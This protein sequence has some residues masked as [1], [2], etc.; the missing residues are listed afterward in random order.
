MLPH[1]VSRYNLSWKGYSSQLGDQHLQPLRYETG[2]RR[3]CV[4]VETRSA[5]ARSGRDRNILRNSAP[6]ISSHVKAHI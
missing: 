6:D 2:T 4:A 1:K 3:L 5:G